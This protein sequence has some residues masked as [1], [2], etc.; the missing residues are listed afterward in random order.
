MTDFIY[1]N[2]EVRTIYR[3]EYAIVTSPD[4]ENSMISF[5]LF[6]TGLVW[7]L[8]REEMAVETRS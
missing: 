5:Q 3:I 8:A 6:C 7:V 1:L 2:N 4:P